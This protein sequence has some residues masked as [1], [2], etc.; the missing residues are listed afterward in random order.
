MLIINIIDNFFPAYKDARIFQKDFLLNVQNTYALAMLTYLMTQLCNCLMYDQCTG[1]VTSPQK[2]IYYFF[3]D[4]LLCDPGIY[5]HHTASFAMAY[6]YS[7]NIEIM[8]QSYQLTIG[9]GIIEISSV[10]LTIRAI[11]KKYKRVNPYMAMVYNINDTFFAVTFLYTRVYLYWQ[12]FGND[13]VNQVIMQFTLVEYHIFNACLYILY[14]LNLYWAYQI[15]Q[16]FVKPKPLFAR[17]H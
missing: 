2:F 14:F 15:I 4:F 3:T 16:M 8:K 11:L 12:L 13:H 5:V 9:F 10:L 6:I 7:S 17:P 1:L